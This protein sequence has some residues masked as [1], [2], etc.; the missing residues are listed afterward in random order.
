MSSKPA[1]GLGEALDTVEDACRGMEVTDLMCA[2]QQI[3]GRYGME[4]I[5]AMT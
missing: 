3:W 1:A 5:Y 4:D 2:K